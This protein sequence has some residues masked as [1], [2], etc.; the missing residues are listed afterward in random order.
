V[1][2]CAV[3]RELLPDY[4]DGALPE[5][6]AG[7]VRAHLAAC[8]D[9][10]RV[11]GR[12][13]ATLAA[14]RGLAPPVPE[15]MEARSHERARRGP[16]SRLARPLA[17][18]GA[19]ALVAVVVIALGAVWLQKRWA[20]A[21]GA[22]RA[23]AAGPACAER[24]PD[25][26]RVN[27]I[28][29]RSPVPSQIPKARLTLG[30]E[31]LTIPALLVA[32]GPYDAA[33]GQAVESGGAVCVPLLAAY[34]DVLVLSIANADVVARDAGFRTVTDPTRVL[35][36]RVAWTR[37][38]RLWRLEGRAPASELQALAAEIDSQAQ[39]GGG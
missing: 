13:Q 34:G 24:M 25:L 9:C 10:A 15:G 12:Y 32:R 33:V 6:D 31:A 35:Y 16:W 28:G 19:W 23:M 27:V 11:F 37:D 20:P 36:T 22:D 1:T 30:R 2:S 21:A 4:Q 3:V 5:A 29:L 17:R 8:A 26:W 14:L 7:A 39:P 38:G 18:P